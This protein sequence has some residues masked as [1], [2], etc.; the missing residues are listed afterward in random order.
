MQ[1]RVALQAVAIV[2]ILI[3]VYLTRK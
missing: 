1:A 3:V 2:L